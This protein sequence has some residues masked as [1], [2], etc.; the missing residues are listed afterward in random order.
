MRPQ[1]FCV[2][3]SLVKPLGPEL[4]FHPLESVRPWK[5]SDYHFMSSVASQC[6]FQLFFLSLWTDWK[7]ARVYT[8]I[9]CIYAGLN[10][11][12]GTAEERTG[13]PN[14]TLKCVQPCLRTG[15]YYWYP[16]QRTLRLKNPT[17]HL[18]CFQYIQYWLAT[19]I[20]L[21]HEWPA[22]MHHR[23]RNV[24]LFYGYSMTFTDN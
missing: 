8:L 17:T 15:D 22:I 19:L 13:N 3:I 2:I 10:I 24:L 5:N 9:S 21:L 16:L 18:H 11:S 14:S 7:P 4:F 20:G 12:F 23:I 1:S 6:S